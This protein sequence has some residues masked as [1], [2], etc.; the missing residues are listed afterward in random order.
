MMSREQYIDECQGLIDS[1]DEHVDG[2]MVVFALRALADR[3]ESE[4]LDED[5][6]IAHDDDE[7]PACDAPPSRCG[8]RDAACCEDCNHQHQPND[9]HPADADSPTDQAG[10]SGAESHVNGSNDA[11]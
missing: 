1:F 9:P 10:T 6:R 5:W 8:G 7:C 4:G 2:D 3:V 11:S